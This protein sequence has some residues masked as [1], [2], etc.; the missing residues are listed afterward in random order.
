MSARLMLCLLVVGCGS[1]APVDRC[2]DP[3]VLADLEDHVS[4]L[5]ATASLTATHPGP[6]EA[7]GFF[8]FPRLEVARPADF[9][10]LFIAPC[11]DG[12]PME[13]VDS[14]G[15]DNVC[16]QLECTGVGR[17]WEFHFFAKQ[18]LGTDPVYSDATVDTAWAEG[19]TGMTFTTAAT[20]E[21]GSDDWSFTGS[22]TMDV[23][24]FSAELTFPVLSSAGPLVLTA[25]VD[26]GGAHGGEITI[27]GEVVAPADPAG[28]YVPSAACE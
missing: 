7:V 3:T 10:G 18:S 2:V 12:M 25:T 13:F 26:A 14:C 24:S 8:A 20:S 9:A 1:D 22:G 15:E 11:A 19:A 17:G 27:D 16:S 5:A 21:S 6:N 28:S 23:D 4:A